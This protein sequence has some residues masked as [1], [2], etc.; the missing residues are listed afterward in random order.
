[1]VIAILLLCFVLLCYRYVCCHCSSSI[2][3]NIAVVAMGFSPGKLLLLF[4][5]SDLLVLN[6]SQQVS[7]EH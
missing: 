2:Y 1:M 5:Q 6:K 7:Q 3:I 4:G